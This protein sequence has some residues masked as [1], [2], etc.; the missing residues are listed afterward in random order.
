MTLS[1]NRKSISN[2]QCR[3]L[4]KASCLFK[5]Y[6]MKKHALSH[7]NNLCP[8][9]FQSRKVYGPRLPENAWVKLNTIALIFKYF[10]DQGSASFTIKGKIVNILAFGGHRV[11]VETT[12]LCHCIA[13]AASLGFTQK[14]VEA[15]SGL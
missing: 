1:T 14:W 7:P 9:T 13:K 2:M 3:V 6:L 4:E 10:L 11:S 15:R 5:A 8:Q 12:L